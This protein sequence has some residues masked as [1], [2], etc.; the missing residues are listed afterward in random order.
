MVSS[1]V[2]SAFRQIEVPEGAQLREWETLLD[3]IVEAESQLLA[4]PDLEASAPVALK[5]LGQAIRGDRVYIFE[6]REDA[7][8]CCVLSKHFEWA[9]ENLPARLRNPVLHARPMQVNPRWYEM[10]SRGEAIVGQVTDFPEA[11]RDLLASLDILSILIIPIMIENRFWGIMGV[12]DCVAV[13]EWRDREVSVLRAFARSLAI[14]MQRAHVERRLD[15]ERH[16]LKTLLDT[17]PDHIY[18]KDRDSKFIRVNEAM[19]HR[20]GFQKPQEM[21]GKC[22]KDL[23]T[24]EHAD[25]ALS[26]E[27]RV[28]MTGKPIVNKE[29][30]ETHP[31]G[32]IT[33]VSTTKMPLHGPDGQVIGTFGVSR[34]ITDRKRAELA[35]MESLEKFNHIMQD[36]VGAL[37]YTS[38]LRDPYT[39]GHQRHVSGLAC[40]IGRKMGLEDSQIEALRVG[41][42]LHDIGKIYVPSEILTKPGKISPV[43]FEMIKVHSLAGYNILKTIDFPWPV[44]KMAHQHHERMDGSG[45]PNNLSGNEIIIEARILSVADVVEAMA[46]HR[47]YRPGLGFEAALQEIMQ[48]HPNLY[49]QDVARACLAV[50]A[51][52]GYRFE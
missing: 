20:H 11:E 40:A 4:N 7:G 42:I 33:W 25:Q 15:E 16:L 38:E 41:G 26:D 14:A 32:S 22:D 46:T 36:T 1:N 19:A 35:L 39:A 24:H 45:Y 10:L 2:I 18:F 50:F 8:D 9:R 31:D 13:R 43:E 6:R 17:T 23:F 28:I 52:D 29:E 21:I 27:M 49:D 30:R 5:V 3:G 12:D 47:P 34:D 44:A 37:A 48:V 51:E